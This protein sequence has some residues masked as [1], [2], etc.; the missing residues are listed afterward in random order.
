MFFFFHEIDN[1]KDRVSLS[2]NF[3]LIIS[4]V[5]DSDFGHFKCVQYELTKEDTKQYKLYRGECRIVLLF[6]RMTQA[7]L[8]TLII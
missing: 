4:P 3:S 5:L 7:L 1:W 8:L 6:W 2:S